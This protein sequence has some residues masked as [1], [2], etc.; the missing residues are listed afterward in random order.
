[1]IWKMLNQKKCSNTDMGAGSDQDP[2][3]VMGGGTDQGT[4]T[5]KGTGQGTKT[6]QGS[7]MDPEMG[8]EMVKIT[9]I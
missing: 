4:T 6:D 5:E 8:M 9:I 2:G 3:I 7:G 1:M